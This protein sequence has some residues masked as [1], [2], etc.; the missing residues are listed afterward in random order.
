MLSIGFVESNL[1]PVFAPT[2][3]YPVLKCSRPFSCFLILVRRH[4]QIPWSISVIIVEIMKILI[5]TVPIVMLVKYK[6]SF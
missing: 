4:C 2:A 6:A 1:W 3:A 5:K